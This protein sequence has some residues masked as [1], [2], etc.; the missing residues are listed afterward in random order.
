MISI[1]QRLKLSYIIYNLFHRNQ[2]KHN[3]PLYKKYGVRKFYFSPVSSKDFKNISLVEKEIDGDKLQECSLFK[4]GDEETK[5]SIFNYNNQ[6]YC[7]I[8]NFLSNDEVDKVNSEIQDLLAKKHITFKYQNKI[9]FAIHKSPFLNSIGKNE[10]LK[11]LL[12]VLIG[13]DSVLFQSINFING[14]EQETHSDSI[15]M[16]TFPLGGLLGV[17]IALEDITPESGALHYYPGSHKL[18]YYLNGDYD[19][20]GNTL[21]IGEKDYSEYEKMIGKK[22]KEN[23]LKKEVFTPKKGDLLVWHANLLHGGEPWTDKTKTRKS[24]VF[25]FFKKEVVCYHERTQRP[26]LIKTK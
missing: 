11:E 15:H 4:N 13:G 17:W 16:T 19:N 3:I 9:M 8:K 26:A 25:H 1:L 12:D 18:P 22:L 14:S 7:V 5:Q 20:N 24:M 23:N 6:G 21:F 2:L 10:H